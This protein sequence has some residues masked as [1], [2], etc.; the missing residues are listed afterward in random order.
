MESTTQATK[1]PPPQETQVLSY[2]KIIVFI[3][4]DKATALGYCWHIYNND[5][6]LFMTSQN[7]IILQIN[8]IYHFL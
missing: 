2:D 3:V 5:E 8:W 6:N 7:K 4:V 1:M